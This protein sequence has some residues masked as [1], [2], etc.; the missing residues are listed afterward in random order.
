MK[1][2]RRTICV[3][4][5]G[6]IGLPTASL[7]GTKGYKVHGVDVSQDI[8]DTINDGNIHIVE[9]DLDIMVK[10]AVG[11]GNLRASTTPSEADIFIIAVP[12]PLKEVT[13]E[14]E[15]KTPT[16]D[17][18]FVEDATQ[19]I[20]PFVKK[21]NLV[22]L[23]STSPLGTTEDVVARILRED[24]HDLEKDVFVAHCPERVLPCLLYTSPSPRDQRGSRM[25]SSA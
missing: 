5:L 21:G 10:S 11:S 15:P 7:L 17:V 6:Y 24:G 18:S 19:S 3:M 20:S 1:E 8:V 12:T 9:P 23:E 4:G 25:P 2:D 13:G 22:I 14:E 16:P